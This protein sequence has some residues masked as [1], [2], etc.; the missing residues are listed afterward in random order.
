MYLGDRTK[1]HIMS[2]TRSS[3]T[4]S[5]HHHTHFESHNFEPRK[6]APSRSYEAWSTET[7]LFTVRNYTRMK[8]GPVFILGV[9]GGNSTAHS[10]W[11]HFRIYG[12]LDSKLYGRDTLYC[13]LLYGE[14]DQI[15]T[16][17]SKTI[18]EKRHFIQAAMWTFH[19]GCPNVKHAQGINRY[20]IILS[21]FHGDNQKF[22]YVILSFPPLGYQPAQDDNWK[23][24]ILNGER[25]LCPHA[26]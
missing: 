6:H 18:S 2:V 8:Y 16:V 9:V 17:H 26:T 25:L 15:V 3:K 22:V 14:N 12:M 11:D 23:I 21:I 13:C 24:F 4:T 20:H 10:T 7:R 19:V 5:V 1:D